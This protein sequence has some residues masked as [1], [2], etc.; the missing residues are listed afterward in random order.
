MKNFIFFTFLTLFIIH[1]SN[2]QTVKGKVLDLQNSPLPG[3]SVYVMETFKGT[4]T[5]MDGSFEISLS[6]GQYHLIASF[7]GYKNDT[8][9]ITLAKNETK[10]M[11]I[12]LKEA[13]LDLEAFEIYETR[14]TQTTTAVLMEIKNAPPSGN[15]YII[16]TNQTITRSQSF[17]SCKK[18]S[19]GFNIQQSI[20]RSEGIE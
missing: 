6:P 4:I 16:R 20:Y 11:Q 17:G 5:D 2:A 12:K 1:H 10:T 7:V 18:I 19:R 15:R 14:K 9:K 8:V 13:S 3:A